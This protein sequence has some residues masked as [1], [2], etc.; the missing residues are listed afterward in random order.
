MLSSKFLSPIKNLKCSNSLKEYEIKTLKVVEKN[1]LKLEF[2]STTSNL[3][4]LD[5][6]SKRYL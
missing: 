2:Q 5:I 1:Q 3:L 4:K 6:H